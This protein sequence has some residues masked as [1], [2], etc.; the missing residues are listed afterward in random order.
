MRFPTTIDRVCLTIALGLATACSQ[1]GGDP[2]ASQ[3]L[4]CAGCDSSSG[5]T[6]PPATSASAFFIT[7][8]A[9][10][11]HGPAKPPQPV[12][13]APTPRGGPI[14][15]RAHRTHGPAKPPHPVSPAPPP[16]LSP[17]LLHRQ[18]RLISGLLP[19][20]A[21]GPIRPMSFPPPPPP[22]TRP[23]SRPR[24]AWTVPAPNARP[25]TTA[26]PGSGA[27]PA[28][29]SRA[30]RTTRHTAGSRA[31]PAGVPHLRA[32][33]A[34][35]V[36]P[37]IRAVRTRHA[38]RASVRCATRPNGAAKRASPAR[39]SFRSAASMRL[40]APGAW[41]QVPCRSCRSTL[42]PGIVCRRC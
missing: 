23:P 27:I 41:P 12:S 4:Q 33:T 1:G 38:T 32:S 17:P 24:S 37:A 20:Q 28:S 39:P 5:R 34:T 40:D 3:D 14:T 36:A 6:S 8:R 22:P 19:P 21:A 2:A 35:A 30:P 11:T 10:R 29:A 31:R 18:I 25:T 26:R 13:F 9:H 15:P 42:P 7:P 16:R